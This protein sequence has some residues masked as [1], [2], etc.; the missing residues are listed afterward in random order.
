MLNLPH[1]VG[2]EGEVSLEKN[3]VIYMLAIHE[4]EEIEIGNLT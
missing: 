1:L 2:E 3:K 4:L